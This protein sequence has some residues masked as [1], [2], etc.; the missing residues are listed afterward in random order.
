VDF[1]PLATISAAY[2]SN[3]FARPN[4]E[5]PFSTQGNTRLGDF[6][7]R[8]LIGA[9]A[10]FDWQGDKLSVNGQEARFQFNRFHELDHYES[11]FGGDFTWHLGL[12]LDGTLS[13]T[14]SRIMAPL[15]DVLSEQLEIETE[16]I[17]YAS[18]RALLTPRWRLDLR[19]TWHDFESPLPAYPQFGFQET[20]GS[21][22][23]NYLGIQKLT[24]GVRVEY[25]NGSYHHIVAATRYDQVISELTANYAVT[26]FSSFD[27][28]A[29]FT[30]RNSTLVNPADA[31]GPLVGTGGVVGR[32]SAFTGALGFTRTLSVKTRVSFHVFREV[33]S[34]VAGANSDIGTG[35]EVA[36]K[37]DPTVKL[38][39]NLRYRMS[40]E[41]IQGGLAIADFAT[42]SDRVHHGELDVNWH[43]FPWLIVRP[44]VFRDT[45][46][47]NLHDANYNATMVGVDFTAQRHPLQ[48]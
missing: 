40:T 20:G 48:Q 14:Q 18:V 19:P 9:T 24:A 47:S 23:L 35:G 26:G 5:P 27:A 25:V 3:V 1:N 4:D 34:Y 38:S 28:Q 11:K 31:T 17:G 32:T 15:A 22:A 6:I 30:R 36:V 45:R 29:G 41:D 2:N 13:Y 37:W 21:V 12:A 43:A 8:Y 42:R 16:K 33:S 7:S 10:Q 44:Y 39:V 46:T